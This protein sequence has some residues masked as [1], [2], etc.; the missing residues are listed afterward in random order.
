M[1]AHHGWKT[2]G[3]Y[4]TLPMR[5]VLS[6]A[7]WLQMRFSDPVLSI[8]FPKHV[9]SIFVSSDGEK[10]ADHIFM[11]ILRSEHECRSAI[12]VGLIDFG[13]NSFLCKSDVTR[14][15]F[16]VSWAAGASKVLYLYLRAA[17]CAAKTA[18]CLAFA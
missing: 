5:S 15:D 8:A 1:R 6:S 3:Q 12:E 7:R 18:S 16:G 10:P 11:S 4:G 13:S 9:G 17:T 14:S 2:R